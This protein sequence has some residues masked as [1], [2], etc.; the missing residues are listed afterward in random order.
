MKPPVILLLLTN[1][2]RGPNFLRA[3]LSVLHEYS[4]RVPGVSLILDAGNAYGTYVYDSSNDRPPDEQFFYQLLTC[5][6]AVIK[7]LI[8]F[9]QQFCLN[10]PCLVEDLQKLSNMYPDGDVQDE[11]VVCIVIFSQDF[12]VLFECLYAVFGCMMSNSCL[13]EQVHGMIRS[14]L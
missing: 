2:R 10:W 14:N 8:H 9:W 3:V 1:Q 13:V 4:D 7:D 11:H 6:D 5:S 12:P